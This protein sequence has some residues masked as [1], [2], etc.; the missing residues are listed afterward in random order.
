MSKAANEVAVRSSRRFQ[1]TAAH[2]SSATLQAHESS[3]SSS[4]FRTHTSPHEASYTDSSAQSATAGTVTGPSYT[5]RNVTLWCAPSRQHAEETINVA[6]ALSAVVESSEC[7]PAQQLAGKAPVSFAR[8]HAVLSACTDQQASREFHR[9][10]TP[11]P[12]TIH[13]EHSTG[14]LR[15]AQ[16]EQAV[17]MRVVGGRRRVLALLST[18]DHA[19][20]GRHGAPGT[21]RVGVSVV[22]AGVLAVVISC[23]GAHH[24]LLLLLC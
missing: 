22:L 11:V 19:R 21:S 16:W 8:A 6:Q 5:L 3:N 2:I 14:V 15:F 4:S 12:A 1:S 20:L 24:I 23:I 10:I 7:S 18:S 9:I 13:S 17:G